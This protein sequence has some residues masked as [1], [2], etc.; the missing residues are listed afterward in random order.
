MDDA[1][2]AGGT[3]PTALLES[4]EPEVPGRVVASAPP[5]ELMDPY[6]NPVHE[7]AIPRASD[8]CLRRVV[9]EGS[10]CCGGTVA[11]LLVYFFSTAIVEDLEV[12]ASFGPLAVVLILASMLAACWACDVSPV[13][14]TRLVVG[15]VHRSL[16][17]AVTAVFPDGLAARPSSRIVQRPPEASPFQHGSQRQSSAFGARPFTGIPQRLVTAEPAPEPE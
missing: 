7:P 1:M 3:D 16:A 4:G 9:L 17:D 6:G 15:Q 13:K 14:V 10:L 8:L 12:L 2:P 11:V 5:L